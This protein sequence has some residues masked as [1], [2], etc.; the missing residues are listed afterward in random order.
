M[1]LDWLLD[2][3]TAEAP[4]GPDLEKTEDDAFLDYYFEAEARL[5]ERYFTPGVPGVLGGAE[6]VIF[7]P[8]SIQL[9]REVEE[10]TKLLQR[11]RDLRLLALLA[12]FQILAARAGDFANSVEAIATLLEERKAEVHPQVDEGTS[13][14]RG[15]LDALAEQPTVVMPLMHLPLSPRSNYSYRTYLVATGAATPRQSEDNVPDVGEIL[16]ALRNPAD[17]QMVRT[18]HEDL[19]RAALALRRIAAACMT[20]GSASFT[21][22]FGGTLDAI[23]DLQRVLIEAN[24]EWRSW[25]DQS[26][27]EP[28]AEAAPVPETVAPV[29]EPIVA[30]L[31]VDGGT[32]HIS[33]HAMALAAIQAA[34]RYLAQFEPSSL[35]LL[36][37]VQ[38]NQLFGKSIVEAIELLMP[39]DAP[40]A[41]LTLGK[42]I[43]FTI[44]MSRMRQLAQAVSN[45]GSDSVD[46]APTKPV[47]IADRNELAGYL[48]GVEEFYL[49]NEPASP[50]P[51]LLGG[52]RNML[53]RTFHA[54]VSEIISPKP[55][56]G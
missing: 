35:S 21:P 3:V 56:E 16:S 2:P 20:N 41:E 15:A 11:S 47:V 46:V 5:P 53:T 6:D 44:D 28:A 45:R 29:D 25:K 27:D 13:E 10:L 40:K 49:R 48:R 24:P 43:G 14:R 54:I 31:V 8:K 23:S 26:P 19:T 34:E 42:G 30:P 55:A 12:R 37:V 9:R 33:D 4:C 39:E 50:I 51:V 1:A 36:L 22:N 52:A 38:A 32:K 17:A 18:Q 7:D